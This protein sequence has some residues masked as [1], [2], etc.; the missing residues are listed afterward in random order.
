MISWP[1]PR[2]FLLP[3]SYFRLP[4]SYSLPTSHSLPTSDFLL[5]PACPT[6]NFPTSHSLPTSYFLLP[7]RRATSDFRLPTTD[8]L[9][10]TSDFLRPTFSSSWSIACHYVCGWFL[11]DFLS[12]LPFWLITLQKDDPMGNAKGLAPDGTMDGTGNNSLVRSAV[13]FRV[14]KFR[15]LL[16]VHVCSAYVHTC[17]LCMCMCMCAYMHA[18]PLPG[19]Q[20][21]AHA[22][23]RTRP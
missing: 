1:P 23:A 2:Y 4:T 10:P 9:L 20:I 14:I 7:A 12:V 5:L 18:G 22:Q 16:Y 8:F 21:A 19:D 6:S 11:T 15:K 3:T 13:L 17:T